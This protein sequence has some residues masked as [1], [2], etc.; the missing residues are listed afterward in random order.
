MIL[1]QV[2]FRYYVFKLLLLN[3]KASLKSLICFL[4]QKEADGNFKYNIL[5]AFPFS[6]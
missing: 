3:F 2:D 1:W 6:L 4:C 5:I